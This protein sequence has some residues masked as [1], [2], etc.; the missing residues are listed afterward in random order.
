MFCD[1]LQK[2]LAG[3]IITGLQIDNLNFASLAEQRCDIFQRDVIAGLRVVETPARISLD[4]Q[5]FVFFRHAISPSPDAA[6]QL[7]A[8]FCKKKGRA[9]K[10]LALL[11]C[12]IQGG[13][14]R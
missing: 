1:D 4:Q 2:I 10:K 9:L 5:W 11:V 7:R 13:N 6:L 3:E 8:G 14:R 12:A